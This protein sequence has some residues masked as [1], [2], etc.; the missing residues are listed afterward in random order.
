MSFE[1]LGSAEII[2][3]KQAAGRPW[4][5]KFIVLRP[6]EKIPLAQRGWVSVSAQ[7]TPGLG[8]RGH[9]GPPWLS[10]ACLVKGEGGG[11]G[12]CRPRAGLV[13]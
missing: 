9:T 2:S 4:V 1:Q 3:R 10:G 5:T 6:H 8:G 7:M 13:S 12:G 11:D